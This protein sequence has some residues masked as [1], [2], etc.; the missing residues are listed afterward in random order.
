MP[1]KYQANLGPLSKSL[2]GAAPGDM[3]ERFNTLIPLD[4]QNSFQQKAELSV[5][6]QDRLDQQKGLQEQRNIKLNSYIDTKMR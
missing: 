6:E 4:V 3:R 2:A 5:L 1:N